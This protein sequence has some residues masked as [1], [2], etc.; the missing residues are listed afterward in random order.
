MTEIKMRTHNFKKDFTTKT[1]KTQR[2]VYL[3]I[4]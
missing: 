2:K 4:S 3:D 1:E